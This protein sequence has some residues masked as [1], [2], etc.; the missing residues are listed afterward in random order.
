MPAPRP[1]ALNPSA[2]TIAAPAAIFFRNIAKL[3]SPTPMRLATLGGLNSCPRSAIWCN[4]RR[5]GGSRTRPTH[6]TSGHR[7]GRGEVLVGHQACLGHGGGHT[8][9]TCRNRADF[10]TLRTCRMRNL[11][12]RCVLSGCAAKHRGGR[13]AAAAE[14]VLAS[15]GVR[16]RHLPTAPDRVT[17]A[18]LRMMTWRLVCAR[19]SSSGRP[20]VCSSCA[21]TA[22]V[23]TSIFRPRRR[24]R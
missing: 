10:S 16:E 21:P 18:D 24:R 3:P 6:C 1:T 4:P 8:T 22:N 20:G 9:W 5:D 14:S 17:G 7:L 19:R 23:A 13:R 12:K 11:D 2:P 15:A